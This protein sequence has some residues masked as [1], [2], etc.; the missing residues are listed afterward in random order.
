MRVSQTDRTELEWAL[1][2]FVGTALFP[3]LAHRLRW[4]SRLRGRWLL[5]Y[6]ASNTLL[7]FAFRQFVFPRIRSGIAAVDDLRAELGREPTT[8]EIARALG[9][10]PQTGR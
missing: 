5:A 1:V 4:P 8:D 3:R 9:L 6:I 7:G 2:A 10:A